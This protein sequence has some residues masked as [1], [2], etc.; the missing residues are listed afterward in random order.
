[1]TNLKSEYL[2]MV[3]NKWL[4]AT[5]LLTIIFIPIF[6]IFLHE[7]P[8]EVTKNYILSQILESY[9][10]GQ[11]GIII[12]TIL[13]IG[14]EFTKSTLR[15]S[16]IACPNRLK[17][18]FS[19]LFLLICLTILIW[20][21]NGIFS[22]IVVKIY[23]GQLLLK[24]IL[25]LT[26]EVTIT[27]LSIVFICFSLVILSKSLLF[28][29]GISLSFLLGLGQMLLQFSE[30]FLYF[31]ILSTMNTFLIEDS[32]V[33]LPVVNGIIVQSLWAMCLLGLSSFVFVRRGIR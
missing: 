8:N 31:P 5:I 32:P 1:M 9:Y 28:S 17:L 24:D 15:T 25:E 16:A 22:M 10:L 11:S 3:Y 26:I 30:L 19:K 2:K 21:V 20:I 6:I 12:I 23:Y 29:M 33:L 27:S 4:L 18:L 7:N 14:Q 13:N